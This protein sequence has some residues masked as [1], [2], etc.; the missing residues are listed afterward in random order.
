MAVNRSPRAKIPKADKP[1]KSAPLPPE[2]SDRLKHLATL[3]QNWDS[4][5]AAP[6]NP[7]TIERV[8]SILREIIAAGA[9]DIPLPFIAPAN[10]GTLVLEWK[11]GGGK[12]LILDVPHGDELISFLLV[13]PQGPEAEKKTE[14]VIGEPWTLVEV[15]GRLLAR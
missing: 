8:R 15:I 5:G 10:D 12:E 6:I 7:K 3:P 2:L 13:E 1:K 4:Y 14:G 9:K 11:T